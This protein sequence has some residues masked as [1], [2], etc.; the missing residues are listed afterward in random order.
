MPS[1]TLFVWNYLPGRVD[2]VVAGKL[3]LAR[4]ADRVVGHFVYGKSYLA[5]ADAIALDPV[6]LPLLER[7]SEFVVLSGFPGVILDACPDRWGIKVIGRLVGEREYPSGYLLMNDPGRAGSLA[8]SR[9]ATKP[10]VELSSREFPLQSLLEAAEAI[11][12]DREVDPEL[13]KALHPGTGGARPKCNILEGDAVWIAKFPSVKDD[14]RISIPRLE[15]AT[16][17]LAAACGVRAATTKCD[18]IAGKDVCF[19]KRFDRAVQGGQVCRRGY[20]SARTVFYSDPAYRDVGGSYG[21]LA[22]WMTRYGVEAGERKELFRRM[23]FNCAVRNSD[24]HELNH[25]LAHLVDNR[26]ELADAFDVLPSLAAHQIHHHALL[27][28]DSA[29][30]TVANLVSNTAAFGLGREEGL[31]IIEEIQGKIQ[32][33]WQDIAYA[34]GFGDEEFRRLE[35]YFRPIPFYEPDR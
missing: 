33:R 6:T 25:G 13:L 31:A 26:F 10:P 16:M 35:P 32:S 9:S 30:G 23:V 12:Q 34:A 15:H 19:V 24:D 29:A 20:V 11:E 4:T 3:D 14:P 18:R 2:P 1:E 17:T 7:P 22:T 5:R 28:G 27:V 8:F 21:R